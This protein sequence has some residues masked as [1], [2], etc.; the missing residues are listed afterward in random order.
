MH[1]ISCA[2][3]IAVLLPCQLAM[4]FQPVLGQ[5]T[6]IKPE[7][8]ITLFNGK[9]LSG[10]TTWLSD[11]HRKDPSRVFTVADQIDGVPAIRVSGEKFGGFVTRDSYRDYHLIVEFRWG[12]T[13]WGIRQN[14]TRDSGVLLHCQGPDGNARA[15]FN[16]PWMRSVEAQII[17]GGVGDIILIA[18]YN[19]AGEK[20][21]PELT[22]PVSRD[23][24]GEPC[25]D[26]EAAPETFR[27]FARINWYGRDPD[28]KDELDF[29]GI[30][31]VESPVGEWTRLEVICRG[32][33]LTYIVNGRV[34]NRGFHSSLT[35]GRI[36]FQS[37][38]AEIYFRR[39]ELHPVN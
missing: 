39:I 10:F 8:A 33:E 26:S 17:Q 15:D 18:G 24:D 21:D 31:D 20:L 22:I 28:W 16:G 13:T 1:L 19:R 4:V 37:E 6:P 3:L 30:Q 34:V 36:L 32:D 2:L 11:D 29:R 12:L 14:R 23:R 38:G 35:S 5:D 25:Y 7:E 27:A 9:D